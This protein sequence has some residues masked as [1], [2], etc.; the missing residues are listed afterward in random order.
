MGK[1]SDY[2]KNTSVSLF[3]KEKRIP[4]LRN[5]DTLKEYEELP[6]ISENLIVIT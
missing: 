6:K 4:D 5:R 2:V 1:V 3:C